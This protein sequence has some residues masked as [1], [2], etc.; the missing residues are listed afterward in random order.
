[1]WLRSILFLLP[2]LFLRVLS[3]L[4]DSS[5]AWLLARLL[6]FF[7]VPELTLLFG[8]VRVLL[9]DRGLTLVSDP[10]ATRLSVPVRAGFTVLLSAPPS[11]PPVDFL[12][13]SWSFFLLGFPLFLSPLSFSSLPPSQ[14]LLG[15]LFPFP[16]T[17]A[18]LALMHTDHCPMA[19]GLP[20]LTVTCNPPVNR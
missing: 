17:G 9:P 20:V 19:P 10:G 6:V 2:Y 1:M 18:L 14:G 5:G 8:A 13:P 16:E 11:P 15:R 12:P 4:L 3:C 7:L